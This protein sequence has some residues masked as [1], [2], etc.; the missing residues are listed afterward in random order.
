MPRGQYDRSKSKA[1][2]AAEKNADA[3]KSAVKKARAPYGSKKL[4]KAAGAQAVSVKFTAAAESYSL[5]TLCSLRGCFTGQ[6]PSTIILNKIDTLILSKIDRM[7][8]ET[9][10]TKKTLQASAPI[11]AVAPIPASAPFNP[12]APANGQA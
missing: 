6:H 1:Q 7:L 10:V 9:E 11:Q 8:G 2:R 4:A 12:A 5:E 3:P